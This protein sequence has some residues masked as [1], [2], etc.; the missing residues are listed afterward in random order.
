V[1]ERIA[2]AYPDV[3]HGAL[4]DAGSDPLGTPDP[5]AGVDTLPPRNLFRRFQSSSHLVY[6]SGELDPDNLASDATSSQSMRD[7]CVFGVETHETPCAGHEI[8]NAEAFGRALERLLSQHRPPDPAQLGACRSHLEA[9]IEGR[10]GQAQALISRG[11]HAAARTLLLKVDQRYGG[12]AS[13][14]I[15]ELA[16]QCRCGLAH[17]DKRNPFPRAAPRG[18]SGDAGLSMAPF[19]GRTSGA[20]PLRP[21]TRASAS[22][23]AR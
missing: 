20:L 15:L 11:R 10:L 9:E 5:W 4:L 22:G 6:V 8:M 18:G 16:R 17:F 12:L 2:L 14:R 7:R 13:P 23:A 1:A 3:F 19:P 21:R